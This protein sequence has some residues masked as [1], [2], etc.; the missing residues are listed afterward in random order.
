MTTGSFG[1]LVKACGHRLRAT[2]PRASSRVDEVHGRISASCAKFQESLSQNYQSYIHQKKV[3]EKRLQEFRNEPFT[4]I[5]NVLLTTISKSFPAASQRVFS[6]Y[7]RHKMSY[8]KSMKHLDQGLL[9]Y[10]STKETYYTRLVNQST[11]LYEGFNSSLQKGSERV[12]VVKAIF[13]DY[14]I[15]FT[16][17]G[18]LLSAGAAWFGYTSRR[19]HMVELEYRLDQLQRGIERVSSHDKGE[20]EFPTSTSSTP[21]GFLSTVNVNKVF[22]GDYSSLTFSAIDVSLVTAV[23]GVGSFVLGYAVGWRRARTP[24]LA[25]SKK[26]TTLSPNIKPRVVQELIE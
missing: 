19:M 25:V 24:T 13:E 14:Q 20:D 1:A 2:F 11:S 4:H 6:D 16:V 7:G 12:R 22:D 17:S 26:V 23:S 3:V 10:Y 15:F 21:S 18:T 9:W 8:D 5:T